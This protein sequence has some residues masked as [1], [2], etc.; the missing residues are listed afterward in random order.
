MWQVGVHCV[1]EVSLWLW[2]CRSALSSLPPLSMS[3]TSCDR[4]AY[5]SRH[6]LREIGI[7]L[8]TIATYVMCRWLTDC[9]TH[10]LTWPVMT[11]LWLAGNFCV[12]LLER[13]IVWDT[14]W[15][16]FLLVGCRMVRCHQKV[17]MYCWHFTL[18]RAMLSTAWRHSAWF[19]VV[20]F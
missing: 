14:P 1:T 2:R 5:V 11:V 8:E 7:F 12:V 4:P 13:K 6:V 17:L 19:K 20:I 9:E 15:W 3:P 16:C 10:V 18:H